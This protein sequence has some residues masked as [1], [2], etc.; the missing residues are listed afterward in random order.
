MAQLGWLSRFEPSHGNNTTV[1]PSSWLGENKEFWYADCLP[2]RS[3]LACAPAQLAL[4]DLATASATLHT[5]ASSPSALTLPLALSIALAFCLYRLVVR[6]GDPRS[7]T[8]CSPSPPVVRIPRAVA[9]KSCVSVFSASV[10]CRAAQLPFRTRLPTAFCLAPR[11]LS[12]L[13]PHSPRSSTHTHT[14]SPPA[15]YLRRSTSVAHGLPSPVLALQEAR[16]PLVDRPRVPAPSAVIVPQHPELV[17]S[18]ISLI[19][20]K[21][22]L[23]TPLE[24]ARSVALNVGGIRIVI[25]RFGFS[26]PRQSP[27]DRLSIGSSCLV[28]FRLPMPPLLPVARS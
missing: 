27:F 2:A 24:A 16:K 22:H 13:F 9:P 7:A 21:I 18:P 26:F 15:R 6:L 19:P 1:E 3:L 25:I 8:R 17:G 20:F 4:P 28:S 11:N 14:L 10:R 5:A 12:T 23:K